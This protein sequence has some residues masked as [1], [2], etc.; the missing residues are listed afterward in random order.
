VPM[1]LS[2]LFVALRRGP[3]FEFALLRSKVNIIDVP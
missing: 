3:E 1:L 2:L